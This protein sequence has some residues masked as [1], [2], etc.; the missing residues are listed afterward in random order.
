MKGQPRQDT[1]WML[2][3]AAAVGGAVVGA[4]VAILMAPK[5]GQELREDLRGVAGQTRD[6]LES[7][8]EGVTQKYDDL[9]STFEAHVGQQEEKQHPQDQ[10]NVPPDPE[11]SAGVC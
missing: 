1:N 9:R 11:A 3:V 8:T 10:R 5:S 7:M 6:S 2:V 4:L